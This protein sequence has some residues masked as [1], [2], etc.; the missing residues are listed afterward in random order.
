MASASSLEE[1]KA[2]MANMEKLLQKIEENGRDKPNE[3]VHK[4]RDDGMKVDARV[5]V[6]IITVGDIDTLKE[7]FNCE[8]AL[9]IKWKEPSIKGLKADEIDWSEHWDPRIYFFNAVSI[10]KY[11]VKHRVGLK[12]PYDDETD[13]IPDAQ[14]SIRMKGTFKSVMRL[15]DFPFDYQNLTIKIMSDWPK[16]VIEFS[17][18]MTQKDSVRTDTFTG[19]QEWRLM[20]HVDAAPVEEEK[21]SSGAVNAYPLYNIT[22][23]VKRI[24]NYYMW[25]V[26][27]IMFFITPLA[28][29]SFAVDLSAPE[30][31]LGV[32]LT[33]LLTAVAFKFVVAQSLPNTSYQTLLDYY[34]LCCMVLLCGVVIQNAIVSV[35]TNSVDAIFFDLVSGIFLAGALIIFNVVFVIMACV[36]SWRVWSHMKKTT[37]KYNDLCNEIKSRLEAKSKPKEETSPVQEGPIATTANL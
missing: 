16:K 8:L 22:V 12:S 6:N 15:T 23:N 5:R 13:P 17:K 35:F 28:F 2:S 9:T 24:P 21:M 10:D 37:K 31:R 11:E 33:L 3:V 27:F 1:V 34:V 29:S 14:L 25:N 30:D 19:G 7:E 26:A 18:D 36:K 32:T 4:K 20:K